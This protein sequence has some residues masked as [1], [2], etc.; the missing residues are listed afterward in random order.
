MNVRTSRP[1]KPEEADRNA[2]GTNKG[3]RQSLLW[4]NLAILVK[5]R[6]QLVLQVEEERRYDNESPDQDTK[7]RQSF[8]IKLEVIN[9]DE[10]RN[11]TYAKHISMLQDFLFIGL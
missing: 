1:A 11:E 10:H 2:E 5:L 6:L 7:E 4:L 3:R 9:L 8:L